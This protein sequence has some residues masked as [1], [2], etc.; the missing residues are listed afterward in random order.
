[1][2]KHS[3]VIVILFASLTI[4]SNDL[5]AQTAQPDSAKAEKLKA[6]LID[7][8]CTCIS[9]SDTSKVKTADDVQGLL[10]Q[11]FM[12]DGM[13]LFMDYASA[14]GIDLTDTKKVQEW[15]QKI[16]MELT[17]KCPTL[18]KLLMNMAKD[19]EELKKL[20]GEAEQLQKADSTKKQ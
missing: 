12:S 9:K 1:M 7:A 20:S 3:L 13:S 8:V 2:K 11:C 17:F 19:P 10:M 4:F 16:G 14:S 18:V 5:C 15:G 6:Q